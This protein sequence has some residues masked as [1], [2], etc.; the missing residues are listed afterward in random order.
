[1]SVCVGVCVL[2]VAFVFGREE[3]VVGFFSDG[4]FDGYV[5]FF[6]F[7][8]RRRHTIC[9]SDWS[10]DVCSSDLGVSPHCSVCTPATVRDAPGTLT[11]A[12]NAEALYHRQYAYDPWYGLPAPTGSPATQPTRS[13]E[14]RVGKEWRSRWSASPQRTNTSQRA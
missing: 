6:F 12:A 13:E 3:C 5:F 10:S 7:A 8:S 9:L 14:R 1:M 4:V 11:V 2:G